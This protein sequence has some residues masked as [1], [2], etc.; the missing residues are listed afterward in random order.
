VR[1]NDDRKNEEMK[2][3]EKNG[4]LFILPPLNFDIQGHLVVY[5]CC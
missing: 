2:E 3:E 1:R 5:T 4:T